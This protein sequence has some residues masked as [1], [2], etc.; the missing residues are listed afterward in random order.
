MA[1]NIF[2]TKIHFDYRRGLMFRGQL[3]ALSDL[4]YNI[5]HFNISNDSP[6]YETLGN[7]YDF[8]IYLDNKVCYFKYYIPHTENMVFAA[9][10]NDYVLTQK[11]ISHSKR[12]YK[13][14]DEKNLSQNLQFSQ[15]LNNVGVKYLTKATTQEE[16]NTVMS[17]VLKAAERDLGRP[18]TY[19]EMRERFG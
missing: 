7:S 3:Y 2:L 1:T 9:Q 8:V 5:D 4:D 12:I 19:S 16:L 6:T 10:D 18:M 14:T 15:Q 13:K 17:T 11:D